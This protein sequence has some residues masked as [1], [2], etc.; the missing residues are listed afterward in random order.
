[1]GGKKVS[2]DG[3]GGLVFLTL[4]ELRGERKREREKG[5]SDRAQLISIS[6]IYNYSTTI[7]HRTARPTVN[8]IADRDDG[9]L[10]KLKR[11]VTP[12]NTHHGANVQR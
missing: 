5:K 12:V 8:H 6:I 2:R 3:G 11:V 4:L 1:M 7:V 10:A 9:N